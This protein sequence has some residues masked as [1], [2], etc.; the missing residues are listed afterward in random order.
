MANKRIETYE[1]KQVFFDKEVM[2]ELT[3]GETGYTVHCLDPDERWL[4]LTLISF[5]GQWL[6]RWSTD[7]TED[8]RS[9]LFAKAVRRLVCPVACE[10][11]V[12]R[13][14][15]ILEAQLPQ[16]TTMNGHFTNLVTVVDNLEETTDVRLL[17][18]NDTLALI[19]AELSTSLIPANII[20]QVEFLLNGIAVILGAPSVPILP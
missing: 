12:K 2:L 13:I 18:I 3:L 7:W 11:D 4:L 15:D 6:N 19:E 16:L 5:Y 17:A 10:E 1:D 9:Q 14:A 20:D 8:E